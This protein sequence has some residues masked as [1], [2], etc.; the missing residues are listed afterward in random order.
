MKYAKPV[1]VAAMSAAMTA[2]SASAGGMAPAIE[3]EP[4]EI[5]EETGSG[6]ANLI[7]P[8]ILI[9]LIAAAASSTS[10]GGEDVIVEGP[11]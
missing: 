6:S 3:M 7:I 8:L 1:T 4:V 2:T 9:A 11:V 10:N 5:V